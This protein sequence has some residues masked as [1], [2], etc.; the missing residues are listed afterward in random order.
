MI[1]IKSP[2]ELEALREAG[3]I[4]QE[5]MH[6]LIFSA[7]AGISTGELDHI[8]ETSIR[9]FGAKASFKGY[10]GFPASICTSLNSEVVH[11][12]P[13]PKRIL[14]SGD[15]LKLDLGVFYRDMHADAG[16]TVG[17]GEI[18]PNLVKLAKVTEEAFWVA[19]KNIKPGNQL[20]LIGKAIESIVKQHGFSVVRDLI[21]HGVGH[22]L[23]EDPEIPNFFRPDQKVK[24]EQGMTLAIEPMVNLG[25]WKVKQLKDGWTIVSVDGSASAYYENTVI[26]TENGYEIVT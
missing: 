14:H 16:R 13:S 2:S 20:N 18:A 25:S 17:I 22:D 12:I 11:G 7:K 24:L 23:H 19:I 21:G 10:N 4:H 9:A 5:V 15:L 3:Q 26:V 6:Q 1:N 8:A